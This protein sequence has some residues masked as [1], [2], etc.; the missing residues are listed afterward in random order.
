MEIFL[1]LRLPELCLTLVIVS[2]FACK[3]SLDN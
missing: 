1:W 3:H 2:M